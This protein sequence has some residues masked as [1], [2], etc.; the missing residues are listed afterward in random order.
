MLRS[1]ACALH[2]IDGHVKFSSC[3]VNPTLRSLSL[4]RVVHFS[5]DFLDDHRGRQRLITISR[6]SVNA[7]V[8]R[9]ECIL[10]DYVTDCINVSMTD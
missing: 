3:D 4:W 7:L 9:F 1:F 8:E 10:N 6:R 5:S 2:G